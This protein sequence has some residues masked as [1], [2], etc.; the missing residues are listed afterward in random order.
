MCALIYTAVSEI[1]ALVHFW[2]NY[3]TLRDRCFVP[4]PNGDAYADFAA[5][6]TDRR[7]LAEIVR[8][9]DS[10][11]AAHSGFLRSLESW[12]EENSSAPRSSGAVLERCAFQ[13]L[14]APGA[15]YSRIFPNNSPGSRC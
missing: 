1:E 8:S 4:H 9:D 6:I 15:S 12:W 3:G 14:P 13:C 11:A 2:M 10:V 5:E 7:S